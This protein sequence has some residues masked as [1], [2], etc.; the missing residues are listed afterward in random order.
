MCARRPRPQDR[1]VVGTPARTT[2]TK[3]DRVSTR[4]LVKIS[5]F[6]ATLGAGA[7]LVAGAATGTGAYFTS[8]VD[9]S[10]SS[11]SGHLVLKA[12]NTGLDF[13]ALMPGQDV[14][15]NVTYSID[16][17][18]GKSDVWLTFD[19]TSAGYQA[20][21]GAKGSALAP[22]GGLGRYGH[23]KVTANDGGT[24]FDSYNLA[25]PAAGGT[26]CTD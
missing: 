16:V 2:R 3:D 25:L 19:P 15:K 13:G 6:I 20:F 7:A 24:L 4:N 23:F 26:N 12:P 21:T 8:S 11:S 10:L 18:G 14:T 5:G 1:G 22:D 9:G 17:S